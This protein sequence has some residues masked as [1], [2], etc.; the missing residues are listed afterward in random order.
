MPLG[1]ILFS[2][3]ILTMDYPLRINKYLRDK[4]FASRRE[5]DQFILGGRVLV[6]G[7][8]AQPGMLINECDKVVLH[9]PDK[10]AHTYLAYYKPRGLATQAQPEFKSVI[11]E[12]RG[13]GIFPVGR[14]DKE[15]EGLL[16]LTDD[17]RVTTKILGAEAEFEKEYEVIVKEILRPGIVAIFKKGMRTKALGELLSADAHIVD[18]HMLRVILCEGKR[19]QIRVM[20][21]ELGYSIVSLRRIRIGHIRIGSLR[22]GQT[23]KLTEKE[24]DML[25]A[26]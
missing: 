10:K 12:W 3:L 5:A 9:R 22:P 24:V 8:R 21:G 11:A 17:G 7:K 16:I 20:L 1:P 2:Y 18:E 23:R 19:H 6:N 4:G 25:F 13:K 26:Q 15:S 14:L